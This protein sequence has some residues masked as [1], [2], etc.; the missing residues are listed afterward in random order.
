SQSSCSTKLTKIYDD[1][2]HKEQYQLG[3]I[4]GLKIDKVDHT[5]T[6]PRILPCIVVSIQSASDDTVLYKVCTLTGYFI[7]K[8]K[9]N[10]QVIEGTYF[11]DVKPTTEGRLI[12]ELV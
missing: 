9:I 7:Y 10:D 1:A 6:T 4:V 12:I 5:N 3:D 2:R 11:W 8:A